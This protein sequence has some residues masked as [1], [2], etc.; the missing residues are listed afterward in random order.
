MLTVGFLIGFL[1]ISLTWIIQNYLSA[2]KLKGNIPG[3]T[4]YPLIL[5]DYL[6]IG[7]NRAEVLTELFQKYG[8]TT[9]LFS[10]LTKL[11][12]TINPDNIKHIISD[13]H[14]FANYKRNPHKTDYYY[15][16]YSKLF[17]GDGIF[18]S[19][20]EIWE[21]Q[22]VHANP[23]FKKDKI[24][25]MT[26]TFVKKSKLFMD[27][28]KKQNLNNPVDM[29]N[30]YM[31]YTLEAL[32]EITFG[33]N[34]EFLSETEFPRWLDQV[35]LMLVYLITIPFYRIAKANEYRRILKD[36]DKVLYDI[37][38]KKR[39]EPEGQTD[40]ISQF[41]SLRDSNGKPYTDKWIRDIIFNFM[42]AGRDTTATL[43]TWT[44]YFLA[45]HPQ[46]LEKAIN[47]VKKLNGKDPNNQNIKELKYLDYVFQESMR[48]RPPVAGVGRFAL[49]TDVLPG[50]NTVVPA[51]IRIKYWSYF[52]HRHPKYWDDP[53]IFKPERWEDQKSI[54]KHSYQ[55]VPFN[56]GPMSC[57]GRKMGELEAKIFLIVM[58]QNFRM[59]VC[60]NHA[61]TPY[62]G[63]ITTCVGGCPLYLK[64]TK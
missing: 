43:L 32:G 49:K 37:I 19:D 63:I 26:P 28:L 4:I 56:A 9:Y 15:Y 20:D 17:F 34:F 25:E 31:R 50:D 27:L 1:V 38:N 60:P 33:L 42:I 8:E 3:P 18:G 46:I 39:K 13:K 5:N 2:L 55:Y 57:I 48:L 40:I 7:R 35:Q 58:L 61:Y 64:K 45:K 47:D 16:Y 11:I 6:F 59:E 44:T 41:M 24:V 10:N 21:I 14:N 29:H 30:I 54:I 51:G 23:M 62:L 12:I 53:L 52:I 36:I 22:R